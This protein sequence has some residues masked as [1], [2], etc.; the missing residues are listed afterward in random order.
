ME[1]LER[2]TPQTNGRTSEGQPPTRPGSRR[3]ILLALVAIVALA[4]IVLSLRARLTS[5][6]G[7]ITAPVARE[8]LVRTVTATGTV[9]P[10][11]T[12]LVG[13]QV[14]GTV[15]EQDADFNTV[16]KKGQIL[17]RLDPTS[18]KA[19][20]DAA[21]ASEDQSQYTWSAS[22]ANADSAAQS[23]LVARENVDAA[24][25]GL[26]SAQSQV[27]KAAAA[28]HL[29]RLTVDRDR[30]LLTQ[31]Y[32]PQAQADADVA[33]AVAAESAYD[34]AVSAVGQ[35]QAQLQA[36]IAAERASGAQ[37]QSA[38]ANAIA[39]R[40]LVD[41]QRA[42][43][44]QARYN[45]NNTV[46]RSQINGT[47]IARNITIGQTVAASFQTPTLFTIGKDLTKMEVDVAVGEPDI[48]G[49]RTG[50]IVD[51]TV[52]AYPNRTFHGTVFQ[53]RQ[54]PTTVNN[55]VTY[56]TVVY[57]AN[58]DGALYPGMTANVSIHVAKAVAALVV[59]LAALQWA[60]PDTQ[61]ANASPRTGATSPWGMTDAALTRTIV[62]GRDGRIFSSRAGKIVRIPVHVV[63]VTTTEAAVTP[64]DAT[65]TAGEAVV[66]S[67][68]ASQMA[69]Q[70]TTTSSALT[71]QSQPL[72]RPPSG[73]GR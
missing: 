72:G 67:D 26:A 10:Q 53:V 48:G 63:L 47:V 23:A 25:A 70:Q 29:A 11:D 52:L 49:V 56:D 58:K 44:S 36:Q 35:A 21:R 19:Q 51:F 57:V 4:G 8:D 40:R 30:Q 54:N 18:F 6:V 66:V 43:V 34:A 3:V 32:I 39:A 1:V 59:P 22:M 45:F 16:V 55:V 65:L 2:A 20:L 31:G 46:I 71:R 5:Q 33:N 38:A 61:R 73:G 15:T 17:T 42:A 69:T 28:R 60:P 27:A 14:S 50:D 12:V 9:N 68:T 62:A 24:R 37:A 64:V 13:T 41:A 7:Y